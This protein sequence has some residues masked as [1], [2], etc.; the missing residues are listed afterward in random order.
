MSLLL[1]SLRTAAAAAPDACAID[2]PAPLTRAALLAAVEA[3]AADLRAHAAEGPVAV[4]MDHGPALCVLELALFAAGIAAVVL[5]PFFTEA[6]SEAA[7]AAAGCTL[8]VDHTGSHALAHPREALPEGTARITFTSGS[9]GAP[10]GICLSEDH[11]AQVAHGIAGALAQHAGRHLPILPPGVLLES[12]A[13]FYASLIAGGA[14]VALPQA[15][16]GLADPFRPDWARML[17]A[18]DAHAITSLILVPEYLAGL[19]AAME[20]TGARL[21]RLTLVAVGGARTA[22]SL[23]AR[24]GALGLP[25]RQ[26]YGLTECGSVVSLER[27]DEPA[28]GSVG[29]SL[30]AHRL[31]LASDGEILVDGPLFLGTIGAPRPP[32]PYPTGD[33]GRLDA[34]GNLWIEGRK[35]N[36]IVTSFGRNVAPEW[37]EGVLL[38]Q[39]DILQACVRGDG[40]AALEAL[41]V[42]A[43]ADADIDAALAAANACLPPYARIERVRIVPPFLPT[44]GQ[45]TANGRLRRA[46]IAA[47]YP[48]TDSAMP[49]FDRLVAETREAQARFAM[50]PQLQA[51]LAGRIT[52]PVYIDYLTQAYHHV[53]H[54]VPLM[55]EARARLAHRPQLVAALDEYI[56][57]ETGHEA[58]ILDDIAAAGGDR[59][60]AAA[61][62]PGPAAA[63]MVAHAYATIRTGNPAAFFGMVYVLEGTSILMAQT[64]AKA[65]QA[66]LGLPPQAFRYLTSHGAL[67]QQHMAFFERLMNRIDDPDDQAAIIAMARDM[68]GLFGGIFAGIDLEAPRA[69]A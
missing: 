50:I 60:A 16:V 39:P 27:G 40:A 8:L 54:T 24:A 35:S 25:V 4:L 32:G 5:P 48:E 51:G 29:R 13:G 12:V 38:D 57:E 28:R 11:L 15:E 3:R 36:L 61:S 2:G 49:F 69:A 64:G 45:L 6:Q 1:D 22:P 14:Y 37:V 44:N 53:R 52:R 20:A 7:I 19:V 34:D 9:T 46:A 47:A 59:D 21:P 23:L 33:I 62:S 10:K 31:S 66:S 42:P 18:I 41:V 63:A 58:W 67:D 30:G 43:R 68:F 26:G 55:E 65:V 17:S 56:E